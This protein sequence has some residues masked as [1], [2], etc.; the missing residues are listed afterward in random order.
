MEWSI[1]VKFWSGKKILI[2]PADIGGGGQWLSSRVL[3]LRPRV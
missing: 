2:T 1:G 3:D